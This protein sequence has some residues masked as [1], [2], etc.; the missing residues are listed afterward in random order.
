MPYPGFPTDL[1]PQATVLL[2]LAEGSSKMM[3]NVWI[4]VSNM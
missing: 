2:C 1:Q 3:E 4:T